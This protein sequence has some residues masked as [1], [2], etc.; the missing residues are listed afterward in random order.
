MFSLWPFILAG[1]LW[2]A[3]IKK[4]PMRLAVVGVGLL[5][6]GRIL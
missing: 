1:M 6:L 2:M 5:I 3:G 4:W